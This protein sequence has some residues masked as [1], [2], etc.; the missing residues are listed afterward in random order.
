MT[1][2]VTDDVVVGETVFELLF[3][4]SLWLDEAVV[5]VLLT[6]VLFEVVLFEVVLFC[7]LPPVEV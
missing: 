1:V 5:Y 2:C 3:F 7:E 6:V 4:V